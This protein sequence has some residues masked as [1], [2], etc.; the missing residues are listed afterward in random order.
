MMK[1]K[2]FYALVPAVLLLTGCWGSR[3]VSADKDL[4]ELY[5]GKTYYEVLDDFGRPNSTVDDG[6]QGTQA[7]YKDVSLRGTRAA[8][9]YRQYNM[10]N[11]STRESGEPTGDVTFRFN[12]KMRCYA[13][14]SNLQHERVKAK[15]EDPVQRDPNRWAWQ[16]PKVPRTIDFPTV[17]NCSPMAEVVSVERVVVTKEYTKI[18]LRYRSRTPER[19]PV[20]DNGIWLM[21]EVYIED[22]ATG[23]RAKL[24]EAEGISLYPEATFFSHNSGGYDVIN[25][26]LTFG[27]VDRRTVKINL[28]EPGHSGRS[29]YGIDIATRIENRLE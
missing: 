1:N 13:V 29:F 14:S 2:I 18:H 9:M 7:L 20:P 4:E 16:N 24:L 25:Y 17:D 26:T 12:S 19:R 5:V 21:P 22:A 23:E 3:Y 28:V 15:K 8:H 10:R 11:K 27:P 6:H